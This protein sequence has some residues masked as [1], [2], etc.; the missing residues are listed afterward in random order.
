MSLP[1]GAGRR[2]F[3]NGTYGQGRTIIKKSFT[4][5]GRRDFRSPGPA[6]LACT[7]PVERLGEDRTRFHSPVPVPACLDSPVHHMAFRLDLPYRTRHVPRTDLQL[8]FILYPPL[9]PPGCNDRS[10]ARIS[11]ASVVFSCRIVPALSRRGR[12]CTDFHRTWR[13]FRKFPGIRGGGTL[14]SVCRT[15]ISLCGDARTRAVRTCEADPVAS[16]QR[17]SSRSPCPARSPQ[18]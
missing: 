10:D 16:L 9:V 8:G 14:F 4:S 7:R 17:L 12:L 2:N 5:Q 13:V 3:Q 1:R 15:G 18:G 11:P 6:R